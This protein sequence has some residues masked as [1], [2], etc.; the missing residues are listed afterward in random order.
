[1]IIFNKLCSWCL[2]LL[3]LLKQRNK[4]RKSTMCLLQIRNKAMPTAVRPYALPGSWT[5]DESAA[6]LGCQVW[7]VPAHLTH[8][9]LFGVLCTWLQGATHAAPPDDHTGHLLYF[10]LCL[11][12]FKVCPLGLLN[13][14]GWLFSLKSPT[15]GQEDRFIKETVPPPLFS[16]FI[17]HSSDLECGWLWGDWLLSQGGTEEKG[18]LVPNMINIT[19]TKEIS[20]L[21]STWPKTQLVQT[22]N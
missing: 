9:L 20:K 10:R 21:A 14:V 1:M 16:K 12:R 2:L 7:V 4:E 6:W 22:C 5:T 11:A 15:W 13:S 17:I 3:A 8:G 19:V 18:D